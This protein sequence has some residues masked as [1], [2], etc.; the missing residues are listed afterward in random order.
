VI[1]SMRM[2]GR[3]HW[4]DCFRFWHAGWYRRRNHPCQIL[5]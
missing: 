5:C 1:D 2:P 4:G 3:P